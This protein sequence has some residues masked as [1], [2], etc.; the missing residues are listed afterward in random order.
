MRKGGYG[1]FAIGEATGKVRL[2]K[3]EMPREYNLKRKGRQIWGVWAKEN[4]LYIS[5]EMDALKGKARNVRM[6]CKISLDSRNRMSVPSYLDG[7]DA[8]IEG[9]ISTIKVTFN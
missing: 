8:E 5:D 6:I 2:S 9:C 1:M 3:L 7:C 4:E